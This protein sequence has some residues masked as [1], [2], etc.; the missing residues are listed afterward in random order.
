MMNIA[1]EEALAFF[2]KMKS[3]VQKKSFKTL[4][5]RSS[6]QIVNHGVLPKFILRRIGEYY[7]NSM[8]K[9]RNQAGTA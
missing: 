5:V 4:F 3:S 7:Y 9:N 6:K 2:H 8:I 1:E